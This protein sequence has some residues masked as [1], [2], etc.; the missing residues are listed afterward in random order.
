MITAKTLA[1]LGDV[2]GLLSGIKMVYLVMARQATA[3]KSRS[4]FG[5]TLKIRC[6][7][8]PNLFEWHR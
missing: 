6:C 2:R 5:G 4:R 7:T 8:P 1:V 3:K